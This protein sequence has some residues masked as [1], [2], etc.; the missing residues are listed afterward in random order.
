MKRHLGISITL[1]LLL[2][3]RVG[4]LC[5]TNDQD[6]LVILERVLHYRENLLEAEDTVT[7]NYY[8]RY[9]F[10]TQRRNFTLVTIPTMRAIA[11]GSREYA[12]ESFWDI[13]VADGMM[14]SA[15]QRLNV[16]T[17]PRNRNVMSTAWKYLMPNIY[18]KTLFEG[19][20]LSPFNVHNTKLY[21]YHVNPMPGTMAEIT[22][23]R[24]RRNTQLVSGSALVDKNTGKIL[25]VNIKGEYD[26]IIF[27]INAQYNLNGAYSLFPKTCDIR[28][29][30]NFLGN[31][32]VVNYSSVFDNNVTLPDT[33]RNSHDMTLMEDVRPIPL[34]DQVRAIYH[35]YDSTLI[36]RD[37]MSGDSVS[38][39]RWDQVLWN[40]VGEH[41]IQRTKGRFG[42]DN[43][44]SFR[45]SPLL[46]P[47]Y[48][49][50]T[51]HKGFTYKLRFRINYEFTPNR[52]I[53]LNLRG[54]YSFKQRQLYYTI[55]VTFRYN[56]RKNAY[57]RV[58]LGNGNRINYSNVF[59]E[60]RRAQLDSLAGPQESLKTFRD[61]YVKARNNYEFSSH[62]GGQIGLVYHRRSAVN[63]EALRLLDIAP[64]Y[65]SLAP[66][67]ELKWRPWGW[68]GPQ[69]T[70]DYE[71]GLKIGKI[72]LDYER[73]EM[74]ASWRRPFNRLRSLSMRLG[75]GIYTREAKNSHFL[76]FNYFHD[77]TIPEGWNDDWSGSFQLLG[78]SRYNSSKYYVR[79]NVTYESPLMLLSYLPL[80]GRLMETERIYVNGLVM[81]HFHPYMEYGYGFETRLFSLGAFIA[82][83]NIKYDGIGCRFAFEL[84]RDW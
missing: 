81:A 47:I 67:L 43:Q 36:A 18:G 21:K 54:G 17:V 75:G 74:D 66:S 79:A 22:F 32:I 44:G 64:R 1:F 80:V 38:H 30:F 69:F 51:G 83:R 29:I 60:G 76:D 26:M 61:F 27:Y 78:S 59:N 28:A 77:E 42:S 31:R 71:R 35:A 55:P 45:L 34:S 37:S 23:K 49:G 16:G 5:A 73:V 68:N 50:Y 33:L 11:S 58:E 40:S 9:S 53:G 82:F 56:K 13:Q 24:K 57:V 39:H 62:W 4:G 2:F 12:G 48:L 14:T 46:N 84:F 25:W 10:D 3:M 6:S 20:M 65:Y 72:D 7:T 41:M 52:D 19:Q 8:L 15:V 63:K 70:I